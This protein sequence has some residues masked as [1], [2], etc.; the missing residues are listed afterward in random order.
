MGSDS[1]ETCRRTM[2][3]P[4]RAALHGFNERISKDCLILAK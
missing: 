4:A 3:V 1:G 2:R